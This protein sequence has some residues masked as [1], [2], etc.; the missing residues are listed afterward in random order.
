MGPFPDGNFYGNGGEFE[1]G[2]RVSV[3]GQQT[4]CAHYPVTESIDKPE[5]FN[6]LGQY[7]ISVGVHIREIL[8]ITSAE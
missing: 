3:L 5:R 1:Y 6:G 4:L 2:G 8:R 7:R